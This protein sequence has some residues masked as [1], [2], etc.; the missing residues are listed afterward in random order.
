M[1]R[2]RSRELKRRGAGVIEITIVNG[3]NAVYDVP[4][5]RALGQ[6]VQ[7]AVEDIF[8]GYTLQGKL[9]S[10]EHFYERYYVPT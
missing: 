10:N 4:T 9:V 8:V 5:T 7:S 2:N 6:V 3:F 1:T